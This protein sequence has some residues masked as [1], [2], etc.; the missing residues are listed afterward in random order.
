MLNF[1]NHIYIYIGS[2]LAPQ[3]NH[4]FGM[5]DPVLVAVEGRK[6]I[7][8]HKRFA[9]DILTF[10]LAGPLRP[11]CLSQNNSLA[12]FELRTGGQVYLHL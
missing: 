12:L 9:R 7:L 6:Q 4:F 1:L 10:K 11:R 5:R 3:F 8:Q 2:F